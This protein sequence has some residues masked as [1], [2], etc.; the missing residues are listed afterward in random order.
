MWHHNYK[1]E[2]GLFIGKALINGVFAT[3]WSPTL[4]RVHL[5]TRADLEDPQMAF[6]LEALSE[7]D[8]EEAW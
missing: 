1:C 3:L 7:S 5:H 8:G 4:W 6:L 2:V